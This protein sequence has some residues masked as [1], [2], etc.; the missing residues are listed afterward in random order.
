VMC[1]LH[2][3]VRVVLMRGRD[4]GQQDPEPGSGECREE[5]EAQGVWIQQQ[6]YDQYHKHIHYLEHAFAPF[7]CTLSPSIIS[8][9]LQKP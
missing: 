7:H 3:T 2:T 6:T 1:G 9:A 4:W 8:L 5:K